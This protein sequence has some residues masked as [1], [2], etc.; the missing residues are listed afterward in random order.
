LLKVAEVAP[1]SARNKKASLPRAFGGFCVIINHQA[2][3]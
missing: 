2:F 1:Q 3:M